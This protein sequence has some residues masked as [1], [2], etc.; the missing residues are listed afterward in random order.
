[1]E[2]YSRFLAEQMRVTPPDHPDIEHLTEAREIFAN[3]GQELGSNVK[4][5]LGQTALD[6]VRGLPGQATAL[7][8]SVLRDGAVSIHGKGSGRLFLCTNCMVLGTGP[9]DAQKVDFLLLFDFN[10][11]PLV[12]P[13]DAV[14]HAFELLSLAGVSTIIA[15]DGDKSKISWLQSAKS[16]IDAFLEKNASQRRRYEELRARH[17]QQASAA[18]AGGADVGSPKPTMRGTVRRGSLTGSDTLPLRGTSASS[19]PNVGSPTSPRA[20]PAARTPSSRGWT[21]TRKGTKTARGL[22]RRLP[23]VDTL[24]DN[25]AL[26]QVLPGGVTAHLDIHPASLSVDGIFVLTLEDDVFLLRGPKLMAGS[27]EFRQAKVRG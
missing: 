17:R 23:A 18:A 22:Q 3:I 24:P 20:K 11:P 6:C 25:A 15:C 8:P 21:L 1:M 27:D 14:P 2:V 4:L 5:S 13:S 10:P 7:N 12:I 16:T 9:A 19:L 26:Y